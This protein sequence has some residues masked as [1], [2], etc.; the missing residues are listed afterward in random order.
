MQNHIQ[1][2]CVNF[3]VAI[4]FDQAQL[5]KLVHEVTDAERVVPIISASV[6]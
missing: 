6:A 5:P 4:V 2:R 1:Q 3:D